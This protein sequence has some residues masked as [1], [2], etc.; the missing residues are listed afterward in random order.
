MESVIINFLYKIIYKDN[1]IFCNK[2]CYIKVMI[3]IIQFILI[4]YFIINVLNMNNNFFNVKFLSTYKHFVKDCKNLKL[5]KRIKI[6]NYIPY[7]SICLPVYNMKDYIEKAILSILNQSFQDFE[8]II[9]NDYSND[10]TID[11]IKRIQLK[12]DR[13]KIINHSKNLGVYRSR[14][15]AILSS[16]GKYILLMDPDDIILNPKL[17]EKLYNYN[18]IYNLDIIEF[19]VICFIEKNLS[20][21]IIHKY[22]HYHNFIKQFIFQPELSDIFFYYPGTYNNSR[23]QCRIIW[24]KIIRRKILLNSI[25]YIGENYYKKFFI[26]ADDIMINL[27]CFHFSQNYSNINLPGYLYN[28][29]QSSMSRGKRNRKNKKLFCYNHLL[30]LKKLYIYIKD[31]NKPRNFLYY[32]LISIYK[33]LIYLKNYS[34]K[35][36]IEIKNFLNEIYNDKYTYI[37]FKNYIKNLSSII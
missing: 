3:K 12:D 31:F 7:V 19:T 1:S 9:I 34:K 15:D 6:R 33:I 27:I 17:L 8:I 4:L 37:L 35:Y 29:R 21:K 32:E 14:V 18:L 28:I 23:I 5:Y 26:S 24:N 20:F 22:Y 30:Y 11:I 36:K 16:R 13:I 2:C 10:T 25:F